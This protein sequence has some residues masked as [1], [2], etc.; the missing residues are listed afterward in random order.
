MQPWHLAPLKKK[1]ERV[2]EGLDEAESERGPMAT[3]VAVT[4]WLVM[5]SVQ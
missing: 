2:Q 1:A 3:P 5:G 4:D